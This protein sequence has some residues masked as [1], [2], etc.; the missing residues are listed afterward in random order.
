MDI[1][2]PDI[3]KRKKQRNL[4]LSAGLI[5]LFVV[6]SMVISRMEPPAPK[7]D[8]SILWTGRVK[9]GE[10]LREVRGNGSLV[11][12]RILS[13]QSA[14]GGIIEDILIWPGAEVE[15]DSVILKLSNAELEKEIFDLTWQLRAAEATQRQ[16]EAENEQNI[17]SQESAIAIKKSDWSQAELEAEASESLS[18]QQLEPAIKVKAARAR[19]DALKI[20]Y[21]LEVRKLEILK[22]TSEAKV[23][24]QEA[25]LEKLKAQLKLKQQHFEAL[26]VKAGISGVLQQLG[27]N[28][29]LEVG[30]RVSAGASLAKVVQPEA[31]KAVIRVPETQAK[32]IQIGQSALIDT[33]NGLVKGRVARVDPA[34]IEGTVTLDITLLDALPQGAR[35]DMAVDAKVEIERL[36]NVLYVGRMVNSQPEVSTE[37]FRL[38]PEGDHAERIAVK[39]GRTSA[40][41]IEIREGLQEGDEIILSEI[42]R[43]EDVDKI[44]I[45]H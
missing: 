40:S 42:S 21:D 41:N 16:M 32:D 38:T 30:Q 3:L 13:I 20:Q 1:S 29:P 36:Q 10:M 17:F 23:E 26:N 43:W 11:P 6:G 24:V 34:V 27:G 33:R 19:S 35:P 7:V 37:V 9:R 15:Q 2:R 44:K 25:D 14:A 8:R 39:I 12:T 18:E 22:K 28:E 31:L 4:L 5:G 45:E